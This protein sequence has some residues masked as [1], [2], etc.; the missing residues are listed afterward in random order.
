M[1]KKKRQVFFSYKTSSFCSSPLLW[2]KRS[3]HDVFS[4]KTSFPNTRANNLF[5]NTKE[6]QD[7]KSKLFSIHIKTIFVIKRQDQDFKIH[8]RPIFLHQMR[9]WPP[10]TIIH[11]SQ[12]HSTL[13]GNDQYKGTT[14]CLRKIYHP[15]QQDKG[16][17][18]FI[19][20]SSILSASDTEC[21]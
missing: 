6:L 5:S 10:K 16:A 11:L 19:K 3:S 7:F 20:D 13:G 21:F 14:L 18:W 8:S 9:E 15:L 1:F 17:F 4:S 12:W 2:N